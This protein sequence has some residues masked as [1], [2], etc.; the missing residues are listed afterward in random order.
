MKQR[1]IS[2]LAAAALLALGVLAGRLLLPKID[3]GHAARRM[4]AKLGDAYEKRPPPNVPW[5]AQTGAEAAEIK[6]MASKDLAARALKICAEPPSLSQ[7]ARLQVIAETWKAIDTTAADTF[8]QTQGAGSG[9]AFLQ[10]A[11][12]APAP[13]P[14]TTG[15]AAATKPASPATAGAVPAG[16]GQ[17][18][19]GALRE[20]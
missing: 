15:S 9:W 18:N 2:L 4:E 7:S 6:G 19:V 8:F 11:R 14:A 12:Q 20:A 16:A 3:H 13:V 1:S 5:M 10:A 17:D